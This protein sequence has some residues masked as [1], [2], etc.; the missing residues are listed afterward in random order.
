M[1]I[2]TARERWQ[3]PITNQHL[4]LGV[5]YG[6]DMARYD[7]PLKYYYGASMGRWASQFAAS[8]TP[9]MEN[10]MNVPLK[11]VRTTSFKVEV[12]GYK[13][14]NCTADNDKGLPAEPI[15]SVAGFKEN[16]RGDISSS[17]LSFP[18]EQAES[19]IAQIRAAAAFALEPV[20]G[21][22]SFTAVVGLR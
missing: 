15:V 19:V 21:H 11:T 10:Q 16:F 7:H 6:W 2:G 20:Q 8:P 5:G 3:R 9:N 22:K 4:A 18:A 17:Y 12:T 13:N 14:N 1:K